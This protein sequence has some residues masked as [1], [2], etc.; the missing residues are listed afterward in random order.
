MI[1]GGVF[2]NIWIFIICLVSQFIYFMMQGREHIAIGVHLCNGKFPLKYLNSPIKQNYIVRFIALFSL[3]IQIVF[4]GLR[5]SFKYRNNQKFN[6][7]INKS[8][9]YQNVI[10]IEIDD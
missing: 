1:F 10:F 6:K 7:V 8:F 3:V 9:N 5:Q 2:I 4:F